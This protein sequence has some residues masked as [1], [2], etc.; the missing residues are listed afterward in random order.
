MLI[1][2]GITAQ[3]QIKKIGKVHYSVVVT[4]K[5]VAMRNDSIA[6]EINEY[7]NKNA[8]KNFPNVLLYIATSDSL[9]KQSNFEEVLVFYQKYLGEFFDKYSRFNYET[10]HIGIHLFLFKNHHIMGIKAIEYA[11]KNFRKLKKKEK[12]LAKKEK[13][14][15]LTNA[16]LESYNLL[17]VFRSDE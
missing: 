16:D 9:Y 5:L 3:I 13:M 1:S 4:N 12:L 10:E 17:P 14:R 7:I 6:K 8:S 15:K 11:V 2:L